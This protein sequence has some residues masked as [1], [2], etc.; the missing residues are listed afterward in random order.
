MKRP[1][2]MRA[3]MGSLLKGCADMAERAGVSALRKV[4]QTVDGARNQGTAQ[5]VVDAITQGTEKLIAQSPVPIP[6]PVRDALERMHEA[7]GQ[8]SNSIDVVNAGAGSLNKDQNGMDPSRRQAMEDARAA[9]VD[10]E[11]QDENA[12]DAGQKKPRRH[13]SRRGNNHR[14]SDDRQTAQSPKKDRADSTP[15][16]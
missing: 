10:L 3:Q 13:R 4:V 15:N 11:A 7:L 1:Q 2:H 5:K 9:F 12:D 8:L 16:S 14:S 6:G